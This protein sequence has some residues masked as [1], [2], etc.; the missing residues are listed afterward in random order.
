MSS[1]KIW[2]TVSC[3]GG[4]RWTP[5]SFFGLYNEAVVGVVCCLVLQCELRWVLANFGDREW[6]PTRFGGLRSGPESSGVMVD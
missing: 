5:T 3:Y 6:A 4:L 1:F 2:S